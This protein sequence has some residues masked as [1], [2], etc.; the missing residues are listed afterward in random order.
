MKYVTLANGVQMPQLG[1]GVWKSGNGEE[2]QSAIA[3]AFGIGYRHFDTAAF[4]FNEEGVGKAIK[5]SGI[6]RSDIFVTT[7]L[8]NEDQGYDKALKAFDLSLEKLGLDYVDLYLVHWPVKGKFVDTWRAMEAIYASGKVKAI[9]VSNFLQH[10]LEALLPTVNVKPMVNQVEHHPYLVQ[11]N[12]KSF[13]DA[14]NVQYEAWSPL[15]QGHIFEVPFLAEL[16]QKYNRTIAQIVLRWNIQKG[17]VVIPKSI[18]PDRL[19]ENFAI[20]DFELTA[21]DMK[22][23]DSLD[24]S[25]RFGPDPD[26]FA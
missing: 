14:H 10:H 13:C 18:H 1:L 16:S 15:M 17:I 12:L 25:K 6:D 20:W 5:H 7:K 24:Q 21:D 26:L 9:G 23:I 22:S 2:L 8:W 4:Y 19:A 11:S 3:K